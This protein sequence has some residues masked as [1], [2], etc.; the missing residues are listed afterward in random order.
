MST[1]TTTGG[2]L[3]VHY[4]S[5][6]ILGTVE[7]LSA[8]ASDTADEDLKNSINEA[9]SSAAPPPDPGEPEAA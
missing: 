7:E 6:Q 8:I 5:V 2:G 9:L 4:R 1:T 3:V